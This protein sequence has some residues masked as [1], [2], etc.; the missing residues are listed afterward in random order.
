LFDL[1]DLRGKPSIEA[2]RKERIGVFKFLLDFFQLFNR[3]AKWFFNKYM[4]GASQRLTYVMGMTVVLSR[5]DDCIYL[6]IFQYRRC[7]CC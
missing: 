4:F 3:Q 5:D 1:D 2:H 7:I 6:G